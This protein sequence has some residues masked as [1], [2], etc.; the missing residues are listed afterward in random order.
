MQ[1]FHLCL[2]CTELLGNGANGPTHIRGLIK[3]ALTVNKEVVLV[4]TI[5][6]YGGNDHGVQREHFTLP[7]CITLLPVIGANPNRVVLL[8]TGY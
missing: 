7:T 2:C 4:L 5:K 1:Y 8:V 6:A 3:F